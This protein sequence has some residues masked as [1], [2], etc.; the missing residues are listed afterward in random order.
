MA[1][2]RRQRVREAYKQELGELI[3]RRL[4]D[5]R[6]GFVSVTDVDI[7][8]DLRQAK[9]YVSVLGD[10]ES[11]EKTMEALEG[12]RTFLRMEMGKRVR[13]RYTPELFFSLDES[14][15]RGIRLKNLLDKLG[16]G[17]GEENESR[18]DAGGEDEGNSGVPG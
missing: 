10:E 14:I 1:G 2:V 5:P 7:S 11:K 4:K 13:L 18:K 3:Q 16:Q 15:E 9:V 17:N 12:A 6:I 8:G